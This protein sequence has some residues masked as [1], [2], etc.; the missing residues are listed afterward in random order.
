MHLGQH[1]KS[2]WSTK[3]STF[4]TDKANGKEELE[5]IN[6]GNNTEKKKVYNPGQLWKQ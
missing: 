4:A 6:A 1:R 5:L 3:S 2:F